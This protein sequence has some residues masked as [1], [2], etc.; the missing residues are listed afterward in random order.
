MHSPLIAQFRFKGQL[1]LLHSRH[2]R[3]T[4]GIVEIAGH[5]FLSG[6]R[7]AVFFVFFSNTRQIRRKRK[8]KN[9]QQKNPTKNK[10]P[11]QKTTQKTTTKTCK[12]KKHEK[13]KVRQ[14]HL[15]SLNGLGRF[16][17][18]ILRNAGQLVNMSH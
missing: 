15:S 4:G 2:N 3:G 12:H 14:V 13:T 17:G 7:D 11:P 9:K 18:T 5:F 1:L 8:N 10:Q 6:Q 16:C